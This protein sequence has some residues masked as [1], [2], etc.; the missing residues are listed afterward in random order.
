MTEQLQDV[1]VE[2]TPQ[3]QQPAPAQ[4]SPQQFEA[5][6]KSLIDNLVKHYNQFIQSICHFPCAQLPMQESFRHF[7]TGFLWFEKA[8]HNMPMPQ[9]QVASAPQPEAPS[10]PEAPQAAESAQEATDAA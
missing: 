2:P 6:K 9:I 4:L 5:V 3:M 10:Q 7:D 8:I 1:A